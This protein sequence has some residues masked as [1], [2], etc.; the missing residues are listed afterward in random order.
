LTRLSVRLGDRLP[1]TPWGSETL[2]LRAE[3]NTADV[4]PFRRLRGREPT[5]PE[6]FRRW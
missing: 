2:A 3:N 1:S 6:H 5:D 4:A